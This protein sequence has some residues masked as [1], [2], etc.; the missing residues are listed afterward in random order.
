M[1]D[2]TKTSVENKFRKSSARHNR[3]LPAATRIPAEF[4]CSDLSPHTEYGSE[5]EGRVNEKR[6]KKKPR[7][8]PAAAPRQMGARKERKKL[9]GRE[10]NTRWGGRCDTEKRRGSGKI[11]RKTT[12]NFLQAF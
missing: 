5:Y 1:N 12:G 10:K 9:S 11:K 7:K 8:K 4:N 2:E 3:K 6:Q